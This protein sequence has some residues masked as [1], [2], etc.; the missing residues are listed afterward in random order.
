MEELNRKQITEELSQKTEYYLNPKKDPRIYWAKEVTFNY[1][2]DNQFRID[3]MKIVPTNNSIS[4][5][6]H[7]DIYC[8]EIKSCYDDFVSGHGLNF[9]GDYNYV[10]CN[11]DVANYIQPMVPYGVGIMIPSP[12]VFNPKTLSVFRKA[13][14]MDRKKPLLE[15]LFMMY[16]S[17]QRDERRVLTENN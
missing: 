17:F 6:E 13:K 4:G 12:D 16:R 10:I 9:I 1:G 11:R 14:R 5:L 3:Y 2:R 8:F 7:S 15:C